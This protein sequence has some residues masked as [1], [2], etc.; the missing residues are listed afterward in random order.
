MVIVKTYV[1]YNQYE[2]LQYNH[3]DTCILVHAESPCSLQLE[4]RG[5]P[6]RKD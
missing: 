4:H 1:V 3:Q 5:S 2:D 6:L